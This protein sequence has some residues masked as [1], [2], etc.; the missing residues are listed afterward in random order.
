MKI[1][2]T[3]PDEGYEWVVLDDETDYERFFGPRSTS[4]SAGRQPVPNAHL[5]GD[6][7]GRGGRLRARMPWLAEGVFALRDEAIDGIG[8]LLEP[9]GETLRLRSSDARL[10]AIRI[11]NVIDVLD[12]A[13]SDIVR[14]PSS[15]RV[16][17]IRRYAFRREALLRPQAF[18]IPQFLR[19][20]TFLTEDLVR[21]IES[22]GS[23][24]TAFLAVGDA[25]G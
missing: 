23:E 25:E 5:L 16:M 21:Q 18:R 2:R 9:F 24:G 17:D 12:E 19:G 3:V 14:F 13:E 4:W 10:V 11:T 15:G 8:P 6:D 22:R 7:A 20:G 1:Y